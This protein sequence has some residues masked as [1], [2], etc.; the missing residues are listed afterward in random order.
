[1]TKKELV[2]AIAKNAG[3]TIKDAGKALNAFVEANG[4][5][6]QKIT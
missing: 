1:M 3:I 6:I 5:T 2:N 4:N